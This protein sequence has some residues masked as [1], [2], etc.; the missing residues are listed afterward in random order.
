LLRIL[1][2]IGAVLALLLGWNNSGVIIGSSYGSG[3]FHYNKSRVIISV[4]VLVGALMEGNKMNHAVFGGLVSPD[5]LSSNVQAIIVLA[6]LV[7]SIMVLFI[8]STLH[9][10]CSL[11]LI[12]AGASVGAILGLNLTL[13]INFLVLFVGSWLFLPLLSGLLTM[14]VYQP[15]TAVIS[16]LSLARADLISRLGV[17]FGIFVVSYVLGANNVGFINGLYA[18][19]LSKS[20]EYQLII[21]L[22][23]SVSA[24]MGM[25]LWGRRITEEIGVKLVVLS[26]QAI[27][28]GTTFG[29]LCVW[30]FTQEG[31]PISVTHVLIGSIIG[32]ALSKRIAIINRR[33]LYGIIFGATGS[34]LLGSIFALALTK[35]FLCTLNLLIIPSL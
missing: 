24:I 30:I 3:L 27:F 10:P 23:V 28:V 31:I 25:F 9:I 4:G 14:L 8:F 21:T 11:S 15:L 20:G 16:R 13:H 32:A 7:T 1:I 6:I 19:L 34:T 17:G 33:V 35:I 5:N 12:A 18:P 29:A 26:P 2:A 22:V